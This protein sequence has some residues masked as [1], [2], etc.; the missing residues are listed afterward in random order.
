VSFI[1]TNAG[2]LRLPSDAEIFGLDKVKVPAMA[3]PELLGELLVGTT[4]AQ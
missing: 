2:L 1:L 3:Y 4:P